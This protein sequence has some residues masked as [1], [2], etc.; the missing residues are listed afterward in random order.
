MAELKLHNVEIVH[1]RVESFT[2]DQVFTTI[3][4]RAFASLA[5]FINSCTHLCSAETVLLAMKGRHPGDEIAALPMTWQI[6]AEHELQVPGITA[7]R[8]VLEIVKKN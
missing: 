2:S 1:A 3:V 6:K 8:R 7:E 5:D 4:S